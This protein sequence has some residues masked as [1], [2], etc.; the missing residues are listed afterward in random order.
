MAFFIN[1]CCNCRLVCAIIRFCLARGY[2]TLRLHHG[3]RRQGTDLHLLFRVRQRL[4]GQ[5]ERPLLH[6]DV[7]VSVDQVPV[8]VFDLR[9]RGHDLQTERDIHNLA[10]VARDAD[11]AQVGLESEALQQVLRQGEAETTTV[12]AGDSVLKRAFDVLRLLL[13]PT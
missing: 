10:V 7:L 1:N 4:V 9:H 11:P 5:F 2:R 8:D 6:L 13:N 3:N 12:S